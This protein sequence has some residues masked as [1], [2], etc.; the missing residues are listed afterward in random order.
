M[1]IKSAVVK[2]GSYPKDRSPFGLMDVV[3]NAAEWTSSSYEP[4]PGNDDDEG[5]DKRDQ[6]LRGGAFEAS[7]R[8]SRLSHRTHFE[9]W[10][11]FEWMGFRVAKDP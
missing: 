1:A 2:I 10:N 3:G 7:P 5:F 8:E 6:V 4:Y 11:H 9:S